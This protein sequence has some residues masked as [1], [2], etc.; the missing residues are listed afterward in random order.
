MLRNATSMTSNTRLPSA[1]ATTSGSASGIQT[2]NMLDPAP[3]FATRHIG[4]DGKDIE[5]MLKSLGA[6]NLDGLMSE[7][8]PGSIRT[9]SPLVRGSAPGGA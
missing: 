6:T 3:Q 9:E 5:A 4:P 8:V 7:T 2:L 1:R